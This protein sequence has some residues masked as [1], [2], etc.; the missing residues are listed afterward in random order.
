MQKREK[1]MRHLKYE[2]MGA[3]LLANLIGVVFVTAFMHH[4][5]TAELQ[6]IWQNP[7]ADT[8]DSLFTPLAFVFVLVMNAIY[9][10]PIRTYLNCKIAGKPFGPELETKAR[11]RLLNEPFVLIVLDLSMWGLSAILYPVLFW[12]YDIGS[13]V[14]QQ[15]AINSIST[16]LI[17]IT[18]AFFLL[19]HVLQKRLAPVFFP[20]GGLSA[21]PR[22]I[23]IRIRT[24]LVAL[25]VACNIIPLL[26]ILFLFNSIGGSHL[27]PTEVLA[28]LRSAVLNQVVIFVAA[29][30]CLTVLVGRNLSIPFREIIQSLRDI[31]EGRFDRKIQVTTNDEIGYTGDVINEMAEGLKEK[32][33]LRY[34]LFLA[35][36]VQ[37]NLLPK[38]DPVVEGLDIAGTSIY[39][40]ETGGDYFDYLNVTANGLMVVVGDVSDHGISAAMLMTTA[41]AFLRQRASRPG[42]LEE[43]ATDVNR[44]LVRDVEDSGRFMTLFLLDTDRRKKSIC[45]VNAGHDSAMVLN[46]ENGDWTELARTGLPFGVSKTE[47]YA[48]MCRD[49]EPGQIIVIGTDGVWESQDSKG[50]MFGKDRLCK[51]IGGAGKKPARDILNTVIEAIGHFRGQVES[52]DD[53][54][55]VIIKII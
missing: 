34:S 9:E 52:D 55:L 15:S 5:D 6:Q 26:N 44:Q 17:T 8:I 35:K 13:E 25:L 51:I 20:E 12:A 43:V 49:I 18:V 38:T 46:P 3:N 29:G 54:T 7:V 19:E 22:T 27:A 37:Q 4:F 16:G 33:Q 21:V 31:R 10:K 36:E 41:R 47:I 2:M 48:E 11:L 24:R 42:R 50:R 39:C 1:R 32:E 23:R 40:E 28:T 14:I 53:V 45:W 30:L